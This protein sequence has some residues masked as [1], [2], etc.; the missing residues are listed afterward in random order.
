MQFIKRFILNASAVDAPE[1]ASAVT[2]TNWSNFIMAPGVYQ[3]NTPKYDLSTEGLYLVFSAMVDGGYRCIYDADVHAL[4]CAISQ[5]VVYG[6]EDEYLSNAALLSLLKTRKVAL[7]CG[8]TVSLTQYILDSLNIESR[9]CRLVTAD[10]P[11]NYDD[12]HV[13]IE[14]KIGGD[15]VFYDIPNNRYWGTNSLDDYFQSTL[16]P[17]VIADSAADNT[18]WAAYAWASDVFFD[19]VLRTET[20]V[21]AWIDR[22]FQI[23]GITHTD[24]KTYFYMPSGT[25]GRQSWLEGLDANYEVVSYATWVSMFY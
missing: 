11:N 3:Y 20:D 22:I 2:Q 7:R 12:G 23:P 6:T 13:A 9:V 21:Q 25:S 10:T 1:T 15:W 14:V 8:E 17:Q 4:L 24:G 16:T 5:M 19:G 18:P